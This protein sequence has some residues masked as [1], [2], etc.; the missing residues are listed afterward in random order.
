VV[1][2]NDESTVTVRGLAEHEYLAD[3]VIWPISP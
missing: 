2:K 3:I 1:D